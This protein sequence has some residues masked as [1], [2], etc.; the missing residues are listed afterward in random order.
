MCTWLTAVTIASK[1]FTA[2]GKFLRMFGRAGEG[3]GELNSAR[4]VA[5]D[6]SGRVYVSEFKN[7][8]VSVFTS[9]GQFVTS[10][11]SEGEGQ[12]QFNYPRGLAVDSSGVVY[13]C[14]RYNS[15]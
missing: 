13:V 4:G 2:E 12:G 6:S 15:C 10:F 5:I 9:E 7:H 8:S 11:G 1:V 3:R 14:D